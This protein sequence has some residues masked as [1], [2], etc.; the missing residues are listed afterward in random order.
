MQ[1][2]FPLVKYGSSLFFDPSLP[3]FGMSVMLR[4]SLKPDTASHLYRMSLTLDAPAS[5]TTF[6]MPAWTSGSYLIRDYAGRIRGPRC[7]RGILTQISTNRWTLSGVDSGSSVPLDWEVFAFSLGIHDAWL[8]SMLDRYCSRAVGELGGSVEF[9]G[10][11][12]MAR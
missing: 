2:P 5:V 4:Y 7:S 11:C 1:K 3:P 12:R 9:A 6:Y 10:D 8:D